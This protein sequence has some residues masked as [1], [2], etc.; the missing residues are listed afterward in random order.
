MDA[1]T[2]LKLQDLL[3]R[4]AQ[5]HGIAVLLVTHD[6]AEAVHLADRVLVLEADPGRIRAEIAVPHPDPHPRDRDRPESAD[7]IATV[8]HALQV[9]HAL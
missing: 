9:A 4:V 3:L 2:R 1:F 6:I 5:A 7:T 8:R